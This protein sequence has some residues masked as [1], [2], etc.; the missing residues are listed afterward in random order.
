[1][2]RL[3][4]GWPA[5][6]LAV[7]LASGCSTSP[8]A[9]DYREQASL[10][11]GTAVSEV[12]TLRHVMAELA[13]GDTFRQSALT[14]LRY[15]EKSLGSATQS[16][17]SLNPSPSTDRVQQASSR[18]LGDAEELLTEVRIAVHRRRTDTYP[19]LVDDLSKMGTQ[20]EDLESRVR[21]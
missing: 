1:V 12:A 18:L 2:T 11:L 5:A 16:F 3:R 10:T 7:A 8:N 19:E 9:S 15:S 14:Q 4:A 13:E 17:G 21:P 6:V 20:L